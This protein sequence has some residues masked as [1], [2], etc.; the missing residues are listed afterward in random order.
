MDKRRGMYSAQVSPN[1]RIAPE[2]KVGTWTPADEVAFQAGVKQ[3][4]WFS[5]FK[6]QYGETPNLDSQDYNYRAAWKAGVRPQTYEYD[7]MQHW[8]SMTPSGES[9]K[10]TNHPTAWME[11]YMQ[12]TGGVD[13]HE[14]VAL[15]PQQIKAL[16]NAL[17]Y[18]YGR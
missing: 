17:R 16:G 2:A 13:T 4:P 3:T 18:R 8:P 10:A 15:T 7:Q 9:L 5:E 1:Y 6:N 11:D 12:L 14:P